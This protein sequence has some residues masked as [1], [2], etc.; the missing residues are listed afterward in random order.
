MKKLYL[1]VA[2]WMITLQLADAQSCPYLTSTSLSSNSNTYYPPN[3]TNLTAG[4]SAI[5]LGAVP[6]GY[7]GTPIAKG[8]MLLIIQMQGAQIKSDNSSLYGSNGSFG[9]GYLNNSSLYAGNMEYVVANSAVPVTGGTLNLKTPV[10]NT[11][12]NSAYGTDGQYTYQIIR[13]QLYYNL[14]LTGTISAAPWNGTV[15]GVVMLYA[16]NS[17]NFNGQT[18]TAS[19]AGFR[20]GG[21][22]QMGGASSLSSNDYMTSSSVNANGSKGEGIAGTPS[23][24]WNGSSV[25]NT[26]YQG[27]PGGSMGRG[28]PGNAGGGG[29]DGNPSSNDQN[30]GGGGGSN[31]GYGGY[32]GNAWSSNKASGGIPGTTFGQVSA[33]RLVMGGGGGAG[34]SNN[35]T[36]TPGSGAASSGANGGGLVM[37]I[38]PSGAITGT[39]TVS[40]DGY[41]ANNT[42]QNDAGGGGGAGGSVMIYAYGGGTTGLTVTANGGNGGSNETGGGDSHG[43]GGAGG[44][45]FLYSNGNFASSSV[46]GGTAGYTSGNSSHYGATDGGNG[47]KVNNMSATAFAKPNFSCAILATDYIDLSAALKNDVVHLSWEAT[48]AP[49]TEKFV[50]QKSSDG[51]HFSAIGSIQPQIPA[52]AVDTYQY[53]DDGNFADMGT[54]YYRIVEV[55]TTGDST[56]SK[57]IPV[58]TGSSQL[59]VFTAFPNPTAGAVTVKFSS[60]VAKTI[61]LQLVNLQGAVLWQSQ[62]FANAGV[63]TFSISKFS[64]LPDGLYLLAWKDGQNGGQAKVMVR[65]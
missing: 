10:V 9:S 64:S 51:L 50:V 60:S 54:L 35:G 18:V 29:T 13:V 38:V 32:G 46:A 4:S 58:Q 61:N 22:K 52:S 49:T 19:G 24:V 43:P 14:T 5:A 31:G 59:E 62:Y 16:I 53:D 1:L 63:N 8:D 37:I 30:S 48:S 3:Q 11:Y 23:Y 12:K 56:Y 55:H 27:Y 7:G 17:L 25:T 42:V 33:S 39:G 40:A 45:G 6:T 65:H 26:G 44:G 15:G 21:G 47:A 57:V 34:T 36:G 28:A 2:V 20:G 41:S